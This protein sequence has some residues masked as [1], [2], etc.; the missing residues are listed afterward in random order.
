[1][2][3][4]DYFVVEKEDMIHALGLIMPYGTY[5]VPHL[6][7]I[8]VEHLNKIY[9]A[10]MQHAKEYNHMEDRVREAQTEA[11]ILR[12][13]LASFE[14]TRKLQSTARRH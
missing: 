3:E 11:A 7:K 6:K 4:K 13:R 8:P 2:E 9:E 10:N 5:L 14:R 12:R 1:M